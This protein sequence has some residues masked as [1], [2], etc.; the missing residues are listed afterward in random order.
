M[1]VSLKIK[2]LSNKTRLLPVHRICARVHASAFAQ[3]VALG[4]C[5]GSELREAASRRQE[6]GQIWQTLDYTVYK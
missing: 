2:P 1:S 3:K 5:C 6:L 4:Y